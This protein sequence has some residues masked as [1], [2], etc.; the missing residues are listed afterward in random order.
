VYT[1]QN[2]RSRCLLLPLLRKKALTKSEISKIAEIVSNNRKVHHLINEMQKI[3]K[4]A[5]G[6][7]RSEI[8]P[9]RQANLEL[10]IHALLEDLE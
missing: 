10:V 5:L 7:I 9:I 3:G 6:A 8:T 2:K 1:L 4:E